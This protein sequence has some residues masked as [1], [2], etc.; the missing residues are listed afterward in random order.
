[1]ARTNT[2]FSFNVSEADYYRLVSVIY[3]ALYS[4]DV[5]DE[6]RRRLLS[7]ARAHLPREKGLEAL[8]SAFGEIG[9]MPSYQYLVD[10]GLVA[11]PEDQARGLAGDPSPADARM[12]MREARWVR[13]A[14]SVKGGLDE[15]R[16][17]LPS[18]DLSD[19]S[20][21]LANGLTSLTR[22]STPLD[23][24]VSFEEI[25]AK[26]GAMH[27][28]LQFFV[29][30][31]DEACMGCEP[32]TL[33]V[34]GGYAGHGKTT[35]MLNMAY[36]NAVKWGT[37]SD[38]ITLEVPKDLLVEWLVSRHSLHPKWEGRSPL[39]R[40]SIQ[41]NLLS[42]V[43]YNFAVDV[44]ND[45]F[46]NPDYG[47]VRLLDWGDFSSFEPSAFVERVR[48]AGPAQAVF[49]DYLNKVKTFPIPG[50]SGEY[51]RINTFTMYMSQELALAS[52]PMMSVVGGAQIKRAA[53]EFYD[54]AVRNGEDAYY[55]SSCFSEANALEKEP[56]YA[57]ALYTNDTLKDAGYMRMQ[58]LKHRGGPSLTEPFE[59]RFEPGFLFVGD[60][61]EAE[62]GEGVDV[63]S[64]LED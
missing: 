49:V 34:I 22:A 24:E 8:S 9:E 33:T 47:E 38:F 20:K 42:E 27:G 59:A 50:V 30:P 26:R 28:G 14:L 35:F 11:L 13:A 5:G 23:R 19:V 1:V 15:M 51:E 56:Y 37:T 40:M 64:L 12:A 62:E 55:T 25:Y 39:D 41:K 61:L 3:I 32:G 53:F 4:E 52:D 60:E 54:Q 36:S 21:W 58:L 43:D 46:K 48:G 63:D 29:R 18:A 7:E 45:F 17:R 10:R 44:A 57:V 31:L 6:E 2:S 16:D